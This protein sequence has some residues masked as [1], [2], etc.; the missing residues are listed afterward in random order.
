MTTP[1]ASIIPLL[2][3]L[4][5]H[6]ATPVSE[7][8]GPIALW[9]DKDYL[10]E[11]NSV[12]D[13][14][15]EP[16]VWRPRSDARD[17]FYTVEMTMPDKSILE[18][19]TVAEWLDARAKGG[20]AY[21]TVA[22]AME[23]HFLERQFAYSV[24]PQLLQAEQSGFKPGEWSRDARDLIEADDHCNRGVRQRFAEVQ[25][26]F[27]P[28]NCSYQNEEEFEEVRVLARGDYDGDGWQDLVVSGAFGYK[29]GTLRHYDSRLYTKR[30]GGRVIDISARLLPG[31]PSADAMKSFRR[32][33]S[34]SFGLPEN[35]P[36][37]LRGTLAKGDRA[38]PIEAELVFQ[39]GFVRGTYHYTKIQKPIPLEGTLGTGESICLAEYAIDDQLNARFDLSWKLEGENLSLEGYWVEHIETS[40]VKLTG[41]LP[42]PKATA[43]S[44]AN[45]AKPHG[46]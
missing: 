15:S 30:P 13:C 28:N 21:T 8:H 34:L 43:T 14:L 16:Q 37:K 39:A 40:N 11:I 19:K 3:S 4:L 45:Q 5:F 22:M 9:W 29:H 35:V 32:D 36:V 20:F 2:P 17:D 6:T 24:I 1:L 33:L 38:I 31:L 46:G 27:E 41:T 10:S 23:S 42:T 25:W 18:C 26:E 7:G 12:A 44:A